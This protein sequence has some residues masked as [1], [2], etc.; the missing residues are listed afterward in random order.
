MISRRARPSPISKPIIHQLQHR[1]LKLYLHTCI[2]TLP[3]ICL[4]L[5]YMTLHDTSIHR[6]HIDID[7]I[8]NLYITYLGKYL[9]TYEHIHSSRQLT[10]PTLFLSISPQSTFVFPPYTPHPPSC[11]P[12]DIL[13]DTIHPITV[14]LT[15]IYVLSIQRQESLYP[16]YSVAHS[17][18]HSR[19]RPLFV[20]R[21]RL[22]RPL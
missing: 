16:P 7:Y 3:Y 12:P 4:T 9:I 6:L 14:L 5:P 10:N 13:P 8:H 18:V 2:P 1:S 22:S 21:Y 15:P 19:Q 20:P 11:P 17:Y